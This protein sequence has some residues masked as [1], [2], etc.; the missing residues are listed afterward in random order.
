MISAVT[1]TLATPMPTT[2][3]TVADGGGFLQFFMGLMESKEDRIAPDE[4]PDMA[5]A[6]PEDPD[7]VD[8]DSDPGI[9]AMAAP[10]PIAES[11]PMTAGPADSTATKPEMIAFER[12]AS[13][14]H[15]P[16]PQA[17]V[18]PPPT[19]I[20]GKP[21]PV[22]APDATGSNVPVEAT[23]QA[24]IKAPLGEAPQRAPLERAP[25]A[26]LMVPSPSHGTPRASEKAAV[27]LGRLAMAQSREIDE[28]RAGGVARSDPQ[29]PVEG[30]LFSTDAAPPVRTLT[31]EGVQTAAPLLNVISPETTGNLPKLPQENP[32]PRS[33]VAPIQ[34]GPRDVP[35]PPPPSTAP[36]PTPAR[37]E[38]QPA[39][40]AA[41][42][43]PPSA[44][45]APLSDQ[46]P[47]DAGPEAV[48]SW[49]DP[50]LPRVSQTAPAPQASALRAPPPL[51]Q[52]IASQ[53]PADSSNR[54]G[55]EIA[56]Q[57]EELGRVTLKLTQEDG[58]STLLIT[59]ERPETLD[60]MRRHIV[61]LEVELRANGHDTLTLRFSSGGGQSQ[62]GHSSSG[63]PRFGQTFDHD[64]PPQPSK[65]PDRMMLSDLLDIR[66]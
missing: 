59:A 21:T 46:L 37:S 43:Q 38:A 42:W 56:L 55:F 40:A 62:G 45:P 34:T 50:G 8:A 53:V 66:L 3:P 30:T 18:V 4:T 11:R 63:P 41:P 16:S 26:V 35:Q 13:A 14:H 33:L 49:H 29:R 60:L 39:F 57:P 19:R 25:V 31:R 6:S 65:K 58:A 44:P 15:L 10:L 2:P 48:S 12:P 47:P 36:V 32:L 9:E 24:E 1:A 61:A 52:Q 54:A 20:E 27:L 5:Q 17:P 7:S 28:P 22:M 64:P 51:A 23:L